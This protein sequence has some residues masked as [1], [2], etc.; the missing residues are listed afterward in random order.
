MSGNCV[1]GQ[2][3]TATACGSCQTCATGT[4]ACGVIASAEDPNSCSGDRSCN[5]AGKCAYKIKSLASGNTHTCAVL[6]TL[7]NM[8]DALADACA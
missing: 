2:C 4:G 6:M 3:C 1:D 8:T 7:P 5:A